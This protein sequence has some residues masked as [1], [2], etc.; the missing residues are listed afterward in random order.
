MDDEGVWRFEDEFGSDQPAGCC[1]L[2]LCS[3]R[4]TWMSDFSAQKKE[5]VQGMALTLGHF[6][7]SSDGVCWLVYSQVYRLVILHL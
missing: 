5:C 4:A 3:N 6:L 7:E 2:C 1:C